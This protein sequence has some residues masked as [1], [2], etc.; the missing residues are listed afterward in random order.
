VGKGRL[1]SALDEQIRAS[2]LRDRVRILGPMTQM[3]VRALYRAAHLY[4][5]PCIVGS[6]GNREGLPVSIV[7]ALASG[8]P[9]VSTPVTGIPEVVRDG[10]NGLLV[11]MGDAPALAHAIARLAADPLLYE[12]LRREARPSVEADFDHRQTSRRLHELLEAA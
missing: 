3:E 2:G 8:L 12:R 7:E 5:L 6:D 1:R 9:V 10:V 4:V 11:P